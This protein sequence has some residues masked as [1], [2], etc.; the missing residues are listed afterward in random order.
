MCFGLSGVRDRSWNAFLE[1]RELCW[2]GLH[3]PSRHSPPPDTDLQSTAL[4]YSQAQALGP[5]AWW[6]RSASTAPKLWARTLQLQHAAG[7]HTAGCSE[8]ASTTGGLCGSQ[9]P[10]GVSGPVSSPVLHKK[11]LHLL[12]EWLRS[13]L[14]IQARLQGL[15]EVT[16]SACNV[17][18]QQKPQ[19]RSERQA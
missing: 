5:W 10:W 17:N 18:L 7:F 1:G 8:R 19:Q 9:L 13:V 11:L 4:C 12:A 2:T 14:R 6:F 3:K 16:Q 15:P